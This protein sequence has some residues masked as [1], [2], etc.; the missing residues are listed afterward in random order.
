M[1][2]EFFNFLDTRPFDKSPN[3]HSAQRSLGETATIGTTRKLHS[4]T[5]CA[6]NNT[7]QAMRSGIGPD[8]HGLA[9]MQFPFVGTCKLK[10]F[11]GVFHLD[12]AKLDLQWRT[13]T[14]TIQSLIQAKRDWISTTPRVDDVKLQK[15]V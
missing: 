8:P 10:N 12:C 3:G 13:S 5:N 15:L 14:G 1:G 2:S 4:S 6:S 11:G 7:K 9:L